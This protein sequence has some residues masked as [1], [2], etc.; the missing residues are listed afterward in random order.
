VPLSH[1]P[2]RRGQ[3]LRPVPQLSPLGIAAKL[4]SIFKTFFSLLLILWKNKLERFIEIVV[5][6][7]I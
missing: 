5:N 6:I 2:P 4:E 3:H 1:R 7:E